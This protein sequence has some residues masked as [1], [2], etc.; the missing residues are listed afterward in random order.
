MWIPIRIHTSASETRPFF[1]VILAPK[2]NEKKRKPSALLPP[3]GTQKFPIGI[4]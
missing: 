1:E 3:G 2:A 4:T